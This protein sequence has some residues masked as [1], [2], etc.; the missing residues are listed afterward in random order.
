MEFSIQASLS[1]ILQLVVC[2]HTIT[3]LLYISYT[4]HKTNMLLSYY[5]ISSI[6]EPSMILSISCDHVICNHNI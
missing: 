2:I 5:I 1:Y 3:N 6:L 4:F